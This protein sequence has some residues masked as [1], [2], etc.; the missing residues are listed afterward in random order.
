MRSGYHGHRFGYSVMILAALFAAL[1][2]LTGC[3][4][5]RDDAVQKPVA[6]TATTSDE[7]SSGG[8]LQS[9]NDGAIAALVDAVPALDG[10]PYDKIRSLLLE[11]VCDEIDR[12]DGEFISVGDSIVESS[13]GNFE[14]T[15]S[16]AGAI[17]AAAVVTECPEWQDA[18]REFANQ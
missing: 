4:P 17:V 5:S 14:F 11:T 9:S 15:Y 8:L 2:L 12:F 3:V 1:W 13:V 10:V 16:D 6:P 7:S 18:A